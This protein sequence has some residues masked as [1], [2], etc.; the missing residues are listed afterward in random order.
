MK[1]LKI[2]AIALFLI[3][4][5]S[6]QAVSQA[7]SKV[8]HVNTNDL[9]EKMPEYAE[10]QKK[11][12]AKVEELTKTGETMQAELER[13]QR[14]YIEMEKTWSESTKSMKK[15]AIQDQATRMEQFQQM[16]QEELESFITDLQKPLIDKVKKAIEEVAKENG[17][18]HIFDTAQGLVLYS[19]EAFD[20][21]P[22]VAKKLGI[23]ETTTTTPKTTT[24]TKTTT[25]NQ[26]K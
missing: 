24:P 6:F 22:L 14:E 1:T 2:V 21:Y 11:Y 9:L 16:A 17:Y 13:T 19:D 8:G 26:P 3:S 4:G 7:K 12:K 15:L 20:I 18:S 25:P 5:L 10:I 23:V